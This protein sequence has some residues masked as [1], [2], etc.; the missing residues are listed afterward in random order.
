MK[1]LILSG[2]MILCITIGFAQN[3]DV[4]EETV[5]KTTKLRS[6][7]GEKKLKEQVLIRKERNKVAQK[8]TFKDDSIMVA[9]KSNISSTTNENLIDLSTEDFHFTIG[10]DTDEMK[11]VCYKTSTGYFIV[12][13]DRGNG[14]GYYD[15]NKKFVVEYYD[16][17]IKAIVKRIYNTKQ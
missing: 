10:S 11:A 7:N 5:T 3:K 15:D 4:L 8:E 13:G 12:E 17:E 1:K 14:I 9:D 2:M 16:K 6:E